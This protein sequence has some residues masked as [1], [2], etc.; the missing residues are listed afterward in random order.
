[1]KSTFQRVANFSLA[2]SFAVAIFLTA[3]TGCKKSDNSMP[4]TSVTT[5][6]EVKLVSDQSDSGA[7][8]TDPNLVN[9]WGIAIGSSGAFWISA[10]HTGTSTI[11]DRTGATLLAAV[12][13]PAPGN[14]AGGGAPT[15]IV[16]NST[17][18]FVISLTGEPSKFIFAT[19]DGTIAAWSST[20]L[21]IKVAD[22]SSA[23][24]VYKGLTIAANGTAN[25]IYAADFKN[26]KI[27]VFDHA[28]AY[29]TGTTFS[30]SSIPAGFA[31]FNVRNIGGMLYVTYA[32][33]KGPDNMDDES[34]PGNGYVDIFKPDGTLVSRF[35]SQG[36]LNS[37]W[38]MAV[39]PAGFGLGA[40]TIL[41]GNF[42]D[43]HI[44][45]FNQDG[46]V[47]GPL[48][49]SSKNTITIDGL[50]DLA[51]PVN[52]VPAGDPNQLFFTAGPADESHGLFGYLKVH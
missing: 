41:I 11:Y 46:T 10:N 39:A 15:G 42:G 35:A 47:I 19:E 13:I 40:N 34:G 1:M 45:A 26:A 3:G 43:G 33:Q 7:A 23:H 21:A 5:Y 50:W 51:F 2:S 31:P 28:F 22:R 6:D 12:K 36:S 9:P 20:G 18:D 52:G 29:V 48:Q 24:A 30:D 25:F 8:Q 38:G 14:P 49:G 17:T 16:F 32:K 27:D 4:P 44:N 37:P